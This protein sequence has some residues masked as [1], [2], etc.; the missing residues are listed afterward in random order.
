M[1]LKQFVG[2][3]LVVLALAV[4]PTVAFASD[5]TDVTAAVHKF[6][7]NLDKTHVKTAVA[8]CDSPV[9]IIDEFPPYEWHGANACD[10]WWKA[11][12]Q[13]NKNSGITDPDAKLGEPWS[14]DVTGDRAYVVSPATYSFK[15]H[16]KTIKEPNAV[17]TTALRKTAAGWRITGWTWSK[18]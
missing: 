6:F 15:Q 3:A 10:D 18:H 16:G 9:S 2:G 14:V 1:N 17:F 4:T 12:Q 5:K 8:A 13:Y 7:G 11:Y